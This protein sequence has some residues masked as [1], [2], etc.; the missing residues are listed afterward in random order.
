MSAA[1]PILTDIATVAK[2]IAGESDE[3]QYRVGLNNY[4]AHRSCMVIFNYR[5]KERGKEMTI[6]RHPAGVE[7]SD[8]IGGYRVS[9][10]YIG[11]TIQEARER[12]REK[13]PAE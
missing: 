12:F 11:Y 8:I 3:R 10:L 5:R 6:T 2:I 1:T 9:E 7:V 4:R 13:Y